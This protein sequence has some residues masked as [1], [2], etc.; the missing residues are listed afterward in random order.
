MA[1]NPEQL[2]TL[3]RRNVTEVPGH[4]A[5]PWQCHVQLGA[6]EASAGLQP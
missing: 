2:G 5:E 6:L 3:T 4:P 1:V